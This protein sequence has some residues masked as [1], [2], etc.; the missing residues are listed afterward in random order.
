M[1]CSIIE[2]TLIGWNVP[3]PTCNVRNDFPDTFC[4][5]PFKNMGSEMKTGR[6]RSY[7]SVVMCVNR[8]VSLTVTFFCIPVQVWWQW[9]FSQRFYNVQKHNVLDPKITLHD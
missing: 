7:C 5:Q 2:L 1:R 6:R 4:T 8:L 9:N 3:A